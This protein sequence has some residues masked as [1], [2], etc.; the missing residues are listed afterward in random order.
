[1]ASG[2]QFEQPATAVEASLKLIS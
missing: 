2:G 1:L